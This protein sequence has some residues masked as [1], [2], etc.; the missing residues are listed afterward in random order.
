[1]LPRGAWERCAQ[2]LAAQSSVRSDQSITAAF[3]VA[4]ALGTSEAGPMRSLLHGLRR[5]G[6]STALKA[7]LVFIGCFLGSALEPVYP[8]LGAA[9][10]FPPYAVLAAA[11]FFAPMRHWWIYLLA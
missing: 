7:V 10:L 8:Q 9:I 1:M 3:Q 2:L 4:T 11:L 6:A 5:L